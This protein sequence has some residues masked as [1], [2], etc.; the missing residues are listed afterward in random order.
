MYQ[1]QIKVKGEDRFR[2]VTLESLPRSCGCDGSLEDWLEEAVHEANG[3]LPH[4]AEPLVFDSIRP[5]RAVREVGVRRLI[6]H[7]QWQ[8]YGGP[9]EGGWYY[10]SYEAVREFVVPASKYAR[11]RERLERYVAKCNEGMRTYEDGRYG[12]CNGPLPR[13]ESRH[14]C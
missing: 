9:E 12:V 13:R 4:E 6:V 11:L 10:S 14:Y 7:R 1:F 8:N 3:E 2:Q 5:L